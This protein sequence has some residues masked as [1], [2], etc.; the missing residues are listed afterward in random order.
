[1][2]NVNP[3]E[4]LQSLQQ[5]MAD[6]QQQISRQN[7]T[8]ASQQA[9]NQEL[10]RNQ[11]QLNDAQ[12]RRDRVKLKLREELANSIPPNLQ[13]DSALSESERK[14]IVGL[15]PEFEDFPESVKDSNTLAARAIPDGPA[16]KWI[17]S[18]LPKFQ[19]EALDVL[20]VA[21]GALHRASDFTAPTDRIKFLEDRLLDILVL[22]ADNA[23]RQAKLQLKDSFKA[24]GAE[25]AYS[26][27]HFDSEEPDWDVTE[28]TIFQEAHVKAIKQFR[29]F[30]ATLQQQTK[31]KYKQGKFNR[32]GGGGGYNQY[33]R[34]GGRGRG[35]RGRGGRGGR[36]G[37]NGR[38][39]SSGND[40]DHEANDES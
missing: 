20:R 17:I 19:Q 23:Q 22:S 29:A 33:R 36:G 28:H 27:M 32:R 12:R 16:R 14:R 13:C 4:Q 38:S 34:G 39:Q 10:L 15:S 40:R 6:M 3:Y 31:D 30:S 2:Q 11:H 18:T 7:A 1:M 9:T 21:A 35:G 26:L 8:I 37:F 25:G 24:A 5:A